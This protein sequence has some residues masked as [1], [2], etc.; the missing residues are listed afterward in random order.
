MQIKAAQLDLAR[1]KENLAFI[2]SFIDFID[3]T[4]ITRSS[5][6]S[7]EKSGTK[8]F[9]YLDADH[10]Y[11]P[12]E[13]RGGR[14]VCEAEEHRSHPR[15][16]DPRARRDVLAVS[17]VAEAGGARRRRRG[18]LRQGLV[19]G[20][21]VPPRDLRLFRPLPGRNR[22][23]LPVAPTSMPGLTSPGRSACATSAAGEPNGTGEAI[24]CWPSTSRRSTASWPAWGRRC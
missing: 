7:R 11:T 16:L 10:S 9:P 21:P 22:R 20:L 15:R 8:S 4:G 23:D 17:R 1:Q 24:C 14:A 2:R 18:P 19:H 12:D 5:C 6:I 3:N 13:M